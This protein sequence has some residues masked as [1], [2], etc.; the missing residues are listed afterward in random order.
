[1]KR[2][3]KDFFIDAGITDPAHQFFVLRWYEIFDEF[4][5]DSWQVRSSNIKTILGEIL[6]SKYFSTSGYTIQ[7]L[8]CWLQML[9]KQF[10]MILSFSD[11]IHLLLHI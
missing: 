4:T 2:P 5:F 7:I 1:M 11:I 3:T 6:V 10:K 9:Q 8:H